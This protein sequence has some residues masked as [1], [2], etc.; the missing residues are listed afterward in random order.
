MHQRKLRSALESVQSDQ[1]SLQFAF[2]LPLN[3]QYWTDSQTV[4][5]IQVQ[6]NSVLNIQIGRVDILL[7]FVFVFILCRMASTSSI[8]HET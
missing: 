8:V 3:S 5:S 7:F 2:S 1:S 4:L 6:Y